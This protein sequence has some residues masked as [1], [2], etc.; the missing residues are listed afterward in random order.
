M[1]TK[2]FIF[3]AVRLWRLVAPRDGRAYQCLVYMHEQAYIFG[4]YQQL[5]RMLMKYVQ[6]NTEMLLY[7]M[8][9]YDL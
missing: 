5:E 6:I 7:Q 2:S 1:K 3:A 8:T 4:A 9:D